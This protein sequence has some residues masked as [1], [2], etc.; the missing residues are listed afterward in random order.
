[1]S[2]IPKVRSS[3]ESGCEAR[4]EQSQTPGSHWICRKKLSAWS[5]K[6][7][8]SKKE[9]SRKAA[10]SFWGGGKPCSFITSW[11]WRVSSRRY[12]SEDRLVPVGIPL[13]SL[14]WVWIDRLLGKDGKGNTAGEDREISASWVSWFFAPTLNL[15]SVLD[16]KYPCKE[17]IH[18]TCYLLVVPLGQPASGSSK[19]QNGGAGRDTSH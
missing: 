19:L 17:E 7:G 1:M 3:Q 6:G 15:P 4:S 12:A 5:K 8:I 11:A 18:K 14:F 9:S 2:A 16:A 10:K 13:L